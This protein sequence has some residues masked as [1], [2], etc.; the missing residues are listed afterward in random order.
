MSVK[1]REKRGK[2]YLDIYIDGVR[3]WEALHLTLTGD[4][5]IDKEVR[6][7]AELCRV[8]REGQ[9]LAGKWGIDDPIASSV[10]VKEF[11]V[12][13]AQGQKSAHTH[14][15]LLPIVSLAGIGDKPIAKLSKEDLARFDKVLSHKSIKQS[16]ASMYSAKMRIVLRKAYKDGLTA[17][18]MSAH[19]TVIPTEEADL[20]FLTAGEIEAI[21]SVEC[22]GYDKEVQAAFVFACLTGL[23]ISD[24]KAIKDTDIVDVAIVKRQHK[25]G[26]IVRVPL[27]LSARAIIEGRHGV[28]FSIDNK[29]KSAAMNR[30][31]AIAARAGIT[32]RIGWHTA[33]R[34]FATLALEGGASPITVARL[35]GHTGLDTVMKYAKATDRLKKEAIDT[36]PAIV[37][38]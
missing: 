26:T 35:L 2:L 27:S 18:D 3:K 17:K 28:L 12:E 15:A 29:C 9:I 7:R 8:L 4:K 23:R 13:C 25:T 34:T 19:V 22:T 32:K 36:L 14:L 11:I 33:R 38:D 30:L 24:L 20:V 21:A 37:I 6:K 5:A 31:K 16:T 1:I 10:T